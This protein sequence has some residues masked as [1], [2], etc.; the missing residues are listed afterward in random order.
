MN[1]HYY[2]SLAQ[3]L[4]ANEQLLEGGINEQELTTP[5][6]TEIRNLFAEAGWK[7]Q[8]PKHRP[9]RTV[10]TP[11]GNGAP[12]KMIDGKLFRHSLEVDL[13]A[14]N[15]E[16]TRKFLD[17]NSVPLPTG[18][19]FSREDKEIARLYFQ[20]FDGPCV[21][22][23]TNSGGS[24]GVTVGI[25]SNADFEK[26]WD[27]A[28]SSPNTKR[29][30]LEEQVQG[31]ELRL[32]VIDNK[33]AAAAARV[34]PF[35]I[36][37]GKTSLEALII[38]ENESRSLNFRHRRH[39]IVPV[40]EFLKQQSVRIDTTPDLNQVVFLNPF[41]TLRAGAINI[42]VTSHLS[43]DVLNMAVRAVKAIPGLRIAGVDILVSNLTHANGAKV[44]EVN[45]APAID[46]HRFPSIGTPIDLP[47]LMVKYF[48]D[49]PQDA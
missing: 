14:K 20:T 9:F 11:P 41:T 17:S 35:V 27:L 15:K 1:K 30:L 5:T 49:N 39:P 4:L 34:Q 32:F 38:K 16:L 24:R 2:E 26:G 33:V 40:A 45:T 7:E 23:P 13:I 47:E 44:L 19:D 36:G 12:V 29:V 6:R 43:P 42:D 18:T 21:T 46:I 10:F 8:P 25:K 3:F 22:K 28:V 48:T 37:D 31:V